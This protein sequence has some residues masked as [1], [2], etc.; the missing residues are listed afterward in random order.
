MQR[1]SSSGQIHWESLEIEVFVAQPCT[2]SSLQSEACHQ[3]SC[4][5]DPWEPAADSYT[6]TDKEADA[7]LL[8]VGSASG[9][10]DSSPSCLGEAGKWPLTKIPRCEVYK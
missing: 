6:P 10:M 4:G 3:L 1:E 9:S 5:Q 8:G 7:G 2:G